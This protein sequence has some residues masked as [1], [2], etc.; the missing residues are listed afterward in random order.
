MPATEAAMSDA[1]LAAW[2][3]EHGYTDA[4]G[5]PSPP[6]LADALGVDRST[7]WKWLGGLRPIDHRTELALEALAARA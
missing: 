3:T 4:A 2:M 5:D 1:D 6:K 7:V